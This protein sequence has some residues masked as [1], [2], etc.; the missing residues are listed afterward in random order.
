MQFL[1][2]LILPYI[3]VGIRAVVSGD[4]ASIDFQGFLWFLQNLRKYQMMIVDVFLIFD[5]WE[6]Q[7]KITC[8]ESCICSI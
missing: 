1:F 2:G 3:F 7:M 8:T 4:D 6:L 5:I